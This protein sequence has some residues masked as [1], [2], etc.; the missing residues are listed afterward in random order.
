[1]RWEGVRW[2]GV[3]WEG[4]RWEVVRWE[5]VRWEGVRWEGVLDRTFNY[6][7]IQFLDSQE[8]EE[9]QEEYPILGPLRYANR[10][11][12]L[13]KT[14]KLQLISFKITISLILNEIPNI[15]WI[16]HDSMNV[17]TS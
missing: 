2:E 11:Q 14:I 4:V 8:E 17:Q 15:P 5:G 12:K 3:R 6:C 7:V 16:S 1:M 10:G 13:L 9:Q